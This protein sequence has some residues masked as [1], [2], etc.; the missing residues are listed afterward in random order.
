MMIKSLHKR[1]AVVAGIGLLIASTAYADKWNERT[2]LTFSEPVMVPGATLDPGT[3]VFKLLASD[4]SRHIVQVLREDGQKLVTTTQAVP[5]KRIDSKGDIV[6]RFNPTEAGA[7][8]ALKA[9]FYPGSIYGHQFIY[10]DEQAKQIASRTKTVVLAI[11]EPGTDLKKGMLR[12]Y[13]AEGIRGE[14][15]ADES[16]M[17]EWDAWQRERAGN[18]DR[19]QQQPEG[20]PPG[21]SAATS[22]ER[23]A[24]TA[25]AVATDF[26][27]TRVTLEQ[28][29]DDAGKYIGQTVSVDAEVED[30]YGPRL[31]TIDEPRWGDLEGEVLVHVPSALAALVRENDR[32]TVTGEV[33][34]AVMADLEREWG[35][36]GLDPE[37][38]VDFSAKPI[39]VATRIVGGNSDVALFVET[40]TPRESAPSG[41]NRAAS[42]ATEPALSDLDE[43]TTGGDD[44]VG[45]RVSLRNVRVEQMSAHG[46]FFVKSNGDSIFVLPPKDGS[47][48]VNGGDTV[49][50]EGVVLEAP[51]NLGLKGDVPE[52]TNE[53]IYVMAT[54][55]KK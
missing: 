40:A 14:W 32:V 31:F 2:V 33:K 49:T 44:L 10:P 23:R 51:R 35:W 7:P 37:I 48:T 13:N 21:A 28:L 25:P 43:V 39:I 3:Y 41:A 12:T 24:A 30:I 54:T 34:R 15:R 53:D 26:K 19:E 22:A 55:V 42:G 27:G 1:I 52:E 5:L 46:G 9:W 29:E 18:A 36:M 17:Q 8:P 47:T 11:D 6:L 16:T 4:S 38:E 50:I 45:R 20:P